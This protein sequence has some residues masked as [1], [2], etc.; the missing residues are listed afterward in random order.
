MDRVMSTLPCNT[1]PG[2][3]GTCFSP[4]GF[5][6]TRLSVILTLT[7]ILA[8]MHHTGPDGSYDI[9]APMRN[10]APPLHTGP[11]GSYDIGAPTVASLLLGNGVER[12]HCHP[13]TYPHC[14]PYPNRATT[15]RLTLILTLT[16]TLTIPVLTLTV[17][18]E[19][20]F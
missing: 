20:F 5:N 1:L 6:T 9:G 18:H 19:D 8:L 16:L 13:H 2:L 12:P 17:K 11:D 14:H 3:L 15:K 4:P 7:V 10:P